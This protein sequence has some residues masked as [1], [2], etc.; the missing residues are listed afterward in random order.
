MKRRDFLRSAGAAAVIPVLPLPAMAVPVVKA[1]VN[2]FQVGWAA[3]YARAHNQASPALIQKWLRVS[4]EQANALMG[5]LV[6]QNIIKVPIAGSA[7]AVHPMYPGGGVPG[8]FGKTKKAVETAKDILDTLVEEDEA[9]EP[10][11]TICETT[12]EVS[13]DATSWRLASTSPKRLRSTDQRA[14]KNAVNPAP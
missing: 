5:E 13:A 1:P 12:S 2:T 9:G 7:T 14:A 11:E 4:P 3:L 10:I 6:N 8:M